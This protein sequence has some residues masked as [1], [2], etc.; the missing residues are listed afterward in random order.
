MSNIELLKALFSRELMKVLLSFMGLI[1]GSAG[2]STQLT[3][4]VFAFWY[5]VYQELSISL[6]GS[7]GSF[8]TILLSC[9]MYIG[10]T[11]LVA[12]WV[13]TMAVCMKH[14]N[15]YRRIAQAALLLALGMIITN[16]T[17]PGTF[18]P[19]LITSSWL[20]TV[21]S[22]IILSSSHSVMD[23]LPDPE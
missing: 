11:L 21:I 18:N 15:V 10:I 7:A 2:I 17:N 12:L 13:I 22:F 3:M 8:I 6:I 4:G 20:N 5:I 9:L 14:E 19:H 16:Y 1:T 23:T